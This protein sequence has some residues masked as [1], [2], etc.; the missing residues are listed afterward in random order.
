DVGEGHVTER[1]GTDFAE[2][3]A[4][5]DLNLLG[6]LGEGSDPVAQTVGCRV[7]ELA[8][9]LFKR[10]DVCLHAEQTRSD[11][12]VKLRR[13]LA[14]LIVLNGNQS[15]RQADIVGVRRAEAAGKGV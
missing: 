9:K 7:R 13:Y 5:Q 3:A 12:V 10:S 11:L 8:R 14:T 2:Q 1:H 15:L 6:D 4:V